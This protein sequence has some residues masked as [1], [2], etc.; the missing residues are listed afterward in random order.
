[1]ERSYGK[2]VKSGEGPFCGQQTAPTNR[3]AVTSAA[4]AP[5]AVSGLCSPAYGGTSRRRI[6]M[7][8]PRLCRRSFPVKHKS[9]KKV[10]PAQPHGGV[11]SSLSCDRAE[12]SLRTSRSSPSIR[13]DSRLRTFGYHRLYLPVCLPTSLCL[14]A[15]AESRFR[16]RSS[17][18]V[19]PSSPTRLTRGEIPGFRSCILGNDP[20]RGNMARRV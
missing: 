2:K 13:A 11:F 19:V 12:I 18:S 4:C 17:E 3:R 1:M 20:S 7:K 14:H 6:E 16:T 15:A 5:P 10:T 9:L 8:L